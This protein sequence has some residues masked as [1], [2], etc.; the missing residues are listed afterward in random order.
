M[1]LL[2]NLMMA[3]LESVVETLNA[4]PSH[5]PSLLLQQD[6]TYPFMGYTDLHPAPLPLF[7]SVRALL[8]SMPQLASIII[9]LVGVPVVFFA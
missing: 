8:G 4:E 3:A 9:L 2:Q 5:T 7:G 1:S 6:G